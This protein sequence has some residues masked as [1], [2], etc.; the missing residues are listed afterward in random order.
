MRYC[1]KRSRLVASLI[2]LSAIFAFGCRTPTVTLPPEEA[3]LAICK[4]G[5]RAQVLSW[6]RSITLAESTAADVLESLGLPAFVDEA[7]LIAIVD[8]LPGRDVF[9]MK[10]GLEWSGGHLRRCGIR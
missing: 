2:L 5:N 1:D 9:G 8:S 6:N 7:T 3:R 4:K 10:I